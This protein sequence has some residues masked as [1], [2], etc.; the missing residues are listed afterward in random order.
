MTTNTFCPFCG[1]LLLVSNHFGDGALPAET[2]T[3]SWYGEVRGMYLD[4]SSASVKITGVGIL[5]SANTLSAP[6]DFDL[7]YTD[8]GIGA[9]ED[10]HICSHLNTVGVMASTTRA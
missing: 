7:S 10:W 8:V 3:R 5:L 2:S 6:L 4:N 9:L 1:V